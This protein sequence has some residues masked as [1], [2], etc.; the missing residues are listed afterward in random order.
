MKNNSP[1][2]GRL[3]ATLAA[4]LLSLTSAQASNDKIPT[5]TLKVDR[6]LVPVG[7][8]TNLDWEIEY[9]GK[10]PVGPDLKPT[11]DVTMRVRVLGVAFQS[12]STLL[13]F[14]GNVSVNNSSWATFFQGN[15]KAVDPTKVLFEQQVN[16]GESIKFIARGG[17]NAA[18]S[19]WL[20]PHQ[21][22]NNDPYAVVLKDGDT[23]PAYAPAYNQGTIKSFMSKYLDAAGKISIGKDDLIVLWEGSNARPGT[24]YF[25][26]QDLVVLLSFEEIVTKK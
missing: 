8:H 6:A 3:V 1:R 20:T 7:N 2:V 15:E 13:P 25:D 5:G 21:T 14:Q 12:G 16:K 19:S 4:C 9:P 22:N 17:A 18:G 26:M 24:T 10:P 11:V 23:P